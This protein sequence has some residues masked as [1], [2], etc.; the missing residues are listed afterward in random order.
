M[1]NNKAIFHYLNP[2]ECW[3]ERRDDNCKPC[4]WCKYSPQH[5][6]TENPD[7]TTEHGFFLLLE[8]L[9]EKKFSVKT[10]TINGFAYVSL[11]S[12][13]ENLKNFYSAKGQS[14]ENIRM[15]LAKAVMQLIELTKR[16][17]KL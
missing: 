6:Y 1:I 4:K 2:G 14:C 11:T 12:W 17:N 3:H 7:Y 5:R 10:C 9:T 8:G 15:A 13:S 16:D